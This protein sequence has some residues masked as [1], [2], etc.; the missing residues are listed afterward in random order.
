VGFQ[1][2][3]P[4]LGMLFSGLLNTVFDNIYLVAIGR[5]FS[6]AD[7]G[8][9]A[10]AKG[11]QQVPQRYLTDSVANVTFPVF[12]ALQSDP[13]RMKRAASKALRGLA[14]T[15]FPIMVGLAVMARPLVLSL[16]TD[17]WLPSVPYLQLL[18]IIG[19]L[20]PLRVLNN[21]VLKAQGRSGVLLT[22]TMLDKVMV[23]AA[24][25]ATYRLGIMAM[26][27]GQ[28]IVSFLGYYL[29]AHYAGKPLGYSFVAQMTDW[30]P[31]LGIAGAM[32]GVVYMFQFA[33]IDNHIIVAVLQFVTGVTLY[34]ALCHIFKIS[35]FKEILAAVKPRLLQLRRAF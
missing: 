21:D 19:T 13:M 33:P 35:S 5:L 15:T 1:F 14:V 3:A 16:L 29:A 18:C 6:P 26:I 7:L 9:Y 23:V 31:I 20:F 32:G 4:G 25:G 30:L 27:A 24:I 8:F 10:R 22:L 2:V 17:K 12:S 28:A 11:S 34:S